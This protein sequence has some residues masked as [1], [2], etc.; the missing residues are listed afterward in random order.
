MED[1][2]LQCHQNQFLVRQ[3]WANHYLRRYC[4]NAC[5]CF[6]HLSV[7][8]S[9]TYFNFQIF[10]DQF[11]SLNFKKYLFSLLFKSRLF[12]VIQQQH[13]IFSMNDLFYSWNNGYAILIFYLFPST[14]LW[15]LLY[16][17]SLLWAV[18]FFSTFY[19]S[20]LNSL[21]LSFIS[22]SSWIHWKLLFHWPCICCWKFYP[23]DA[24]VDFIS[25]TCC[26]F[27]FS[28]SA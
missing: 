12:L 15:I 20:F 8:N 4:W 11:D 23:S 6:K 7:T 16:S 26:W 3:C 24:P 27:W 21:I 2:L 22:S 17:S 5:A 14:S 13:W 28:R 19:K 18:W 1:R 10:I 9:G 25:A